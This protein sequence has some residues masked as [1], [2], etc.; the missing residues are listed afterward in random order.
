MPP[1]PRPIQRVVRFGI[2]RCD[3]SAGELHKNG[4][5]VKLSDQPFRL[6]TLLLERHGEVVTRQEL[7]EQLWPDEEY[8]EFDD[9]LNTA[10]NKLRAALDDSPENP[11][12]VE[13]IPRR[14]YR[15]IAAVE[16]LPANGDSS[17]AAAERIILPPQS[18]HSAGSRSAA[19]VS[20]ANAATLPAEVIPGHLPRRRDVWKPLVLFGLFA[21]LVLA[22]M[23]AW[24]FY[25]RSALSF[26]SHDSVLVANFDNQTGDPRFDEALETAF[27]VSIEQSRKANVFPRTRVDSVL[28]MMGKSPTARITR[29]LG[30]QICQR[31]GIRGLVA[32]GITRT[33]NEFELTAELID[34]RTGEAV[35]SH[36]ERSDGE[37]HILD[38]L[39]ALATDIRRDLGESL[40]QISRANRPLPE[41]TTSSLSAL[42]QYADGSQLWQQ[43]KFED[44]VTLFRTAVETDPNFAMAHA[45]LGSAYCS[46]IMNAQAAGQREYETAIALSS[47]TTA[48]ERMIIRTEY[49]EDLGHVNEADA[50]YRAY[51]EQYPDDWKM[52]SSYAHLLRLHGRPSEA[53][54]Q[55]QQILRVAPDDADTY[56]QLATAYK[57]LDRVPQALEAYSE[58][59]RL[60]PAWLTAGDVGR[61][62]GAVLVENGE[63]QKTE[64]VFTS[65]LGKPETRE[66][67]LR[68]LALLDLLHG[69]YGEA[70]KRFRQCLAILQNQQAALS[71]ARVHLWLAFVAEGD[72]D[73][74]EERS[75]LDLAMQDFKA[76]GPKVVFG[77]MIGQ[78]YA[79]S[80][81]LDQARKV[82]ALIAPLADGRSPEQ[83]GYLHLLQ[84]EIA[85]LQKDN[86]KAIGLLTLSNKENPTGLSEEALAHAYQAA[87]RTSEAIA[88]YTQFLSA[89]D[90]DIFWE[91]Q[92]RWLR[93]QYTLA[94]DYVALGERDKGEQ[95]IG[96]L[97]VLLKGAD[98]D[99]PLW[100][101]TRAEYA[102]LQ[103]PSKM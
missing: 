84:G 40:Y 36:S 5:K 67:G 17:P 64:Q 33:G 35:R 6:L 59:F 82:E 19:S 97:A 53:V 45:A 44:A 69:R 88:Q 14:G 20:E 60:N 85:L 18:L 83:S 103:Q 71:V 49:A 98:P 72:A 89:E 27:I 15:F 74:T 22:G 43:G 90:Q 62:Y 13:T 9:G 76:I 92:Q 3:F 21:I 12:F 61:E 68:S 94:S 79:R 8:G 77:A 55:Y 42:E 75:Q 57:T 50:L 58:A 28:E 96:R 99:L 73:K 38:A 86:D 24:L 54:A 91:P 26:N 4:S 70:Q 47:R 11:R 34:P 48:R 41:V 1:Q 101:E 51:L 102:K 81:F 63:E 32:L 87:G 39:D 93:A 2:Y 30:R 78:A 10:V 31:E 23:G 16:M 56:I 80:G 46:Y 25:G 37:Q 52:V 100:K 29:S 95:T 7:R 66:R 65:M